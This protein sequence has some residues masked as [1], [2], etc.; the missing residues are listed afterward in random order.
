MITYDVTKETY[1][2]KDELNHF[3]SSSK[4]YVMTL[5]KITELWVAQRN[6]KKPPFMHDALTISELTQKFCDYKTE[7]IKIETEGEKR[8]FTT[9]DPD[10]YTLKADISTSVKSKEF[11]EYLIQRILGDNN[12]S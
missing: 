11:I 12:V 2:L 4:P 7:Y 5:N 10:N 9:I 3:N 1:L 6:Y 8:G